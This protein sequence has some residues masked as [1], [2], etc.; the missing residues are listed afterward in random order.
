M[1]DDDGKNRLKTCKCSS[2]YIFGK[3][4]LDT[5]FPNNEVRVYLFLS[6]S[7]I[8]CGFMSYRAERESPNS[9]QNT[10]SSRWM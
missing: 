7:N 6:L 2:I 1:V 5:V 8:Q 3:R 9:R 10:K 4:Y